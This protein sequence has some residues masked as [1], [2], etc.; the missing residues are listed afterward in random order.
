MNLVVDGEQMA[1]V[2]FHGNAPTSYNG[3]SLEDANYLNWQYL[4]G[5]V[6]SVLVA[7]ACRE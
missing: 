4:P 2:D 7:A 5:T 6:F 1:E 3:C